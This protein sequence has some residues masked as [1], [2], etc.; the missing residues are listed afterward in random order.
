MAKVKIGQRLRGVIASYILHGSQ[1]AH[2][3]DKQWSADKISLHGFF[4]PDPD[5]SL[6]LG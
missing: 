1:R 2:F 3:G 4:G 5:I 6:T